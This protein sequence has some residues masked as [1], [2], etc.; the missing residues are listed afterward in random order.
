MDISKLLL[1]NK[2]VKIGP[3]PTCINIDLFSIQNI[4]HD[5]SF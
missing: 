1:R 5:E 3:W 2:I 4:K